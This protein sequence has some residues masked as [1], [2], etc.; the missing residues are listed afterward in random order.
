MCFV[1]NSVYVNNCKKFQISLRSIFSHNKPIGCGASG[2]YA[3]G[4]DDKEDQ[5]IIN[6][7]NAKLNPIRH[8]LALLG[9]HPIFHV[10]RIRVNV[11]IFIR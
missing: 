10:S 1:Q 6:P 5:Y 11:Q 4:P 8:L 3:P 9:T 2:A 7:L